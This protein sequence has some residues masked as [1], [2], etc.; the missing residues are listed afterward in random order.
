MGFQ[1]YQ[2]HIEV[3]LT[4]FSKLEKNPK[5]GQYRHMN[6]GFIRP[7]PI[8]LNDEDIEMDPDIINHMDTNVYIGDDTD[9]D[10]DLKKKENQTDPKWF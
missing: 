8:E 9:E 1:F 7:R 3:G 2:T 4:D 10:S 5:T 6:T